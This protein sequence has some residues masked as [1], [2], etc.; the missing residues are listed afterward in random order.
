M[1][2]LFAQV[3]LR[4]CHRS[5]ASCVS[6]LGLLIAIT[7]LVVGGDSVG[8]AADKTSLPNPLETKTPDP[9]LPQPS[10]NRPLSPLEVLQLRTALDDLN[11]Q[12][13]AQLKAGNAPAAFDIW[14]RELRLR[15]VLGSLEEVTALGRVGEVAWKQNQTGELSII[16]KRLQVVQTQAQAK[17]PVSIELLQALGIAYQQVRSPQPALEVYQQI[18][19]DA[20]Q[21]QDMKTQEATL[22]TMGQLQLNWFDYTRAAATY[23]Q[24]LTLAHTQGD[25][26]NEAVYLQQLAYIYA[27]EK[28]P[29][30][31][32]RAKEKLAQNYLN[33]KD[34]AQLPALKIAIASDY[35]ALGKPDDASQNYQEAYSLAISIQ[36]YAYASEALQ[37]MAAL[38]RSY[39]ELDYALQVYQARL[40][41]DQQS[42][43]F[44]GLMNSYDQMGQIY[45]QQKR[46]TESLAAFQK[47]LEVA[48]SLK[49]Q[50]NYFTNQIERVSKQSSH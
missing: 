48:K 1:Q 29:E 17:P 49:Y 16:T 34:F 3:L 8:L 10:V 7:M 28:Q 18:L 13:D 40:Q 9:L 26:L 41:I 36:Q 45:L 27:Q 32:L 42:Y 19:A 38:Y 14:N 5:C 39:D 2:N 6:R 31:A 24:L 4:Q 47:G 46:Y 20:Q 44:Y 23:E 35:E 11:S 21:R 15:R 37:K 25:Y 50:E 22:K 33:K 12:A 30:N 43:N